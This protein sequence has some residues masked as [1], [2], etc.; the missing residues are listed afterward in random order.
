[1]ARLPIPA[2]LPSE[3]I[4]AII[5]TREQMPLELAPLQ[6]VRGTLT[7]GDYSVRGLEHVVSLERKSLED[8]LSCMA[9]GRE[10]FEREIDRLVAYPVRAVFVEAHWSDI[11]AGEWRSKLTPAQARA[12][13]NG[14]IARGVPFHFVGD[15]RTAGEEVAQL[16]AIVARRRWREN[17]DL[18][19]GVMEETT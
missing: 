1:M 6:V 13:V 3:S 15:H 10:R 2:E 18:I 8:L 14:W 9:G 11:R 4:V 7:T 16:L 12:A 5:D 17:R 19:K